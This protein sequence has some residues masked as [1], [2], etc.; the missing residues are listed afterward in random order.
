[1]EGRNKIYNNLNK[2]NKYKT[3]LYKIENSNKNDLISTKVI[4]YLHI[5]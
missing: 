1:M 4:F 2:I 3:D 5:V